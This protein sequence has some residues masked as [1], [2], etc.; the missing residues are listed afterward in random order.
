MGSMDLKTYLDSERGRTSA[1]ARAIDAHA[2]D[3]SAWKTG[4]RPV[5]VH[6]GLP[7][8]KATGGLVTRLDLFSKEVIRQVWPELLAKPRGRKMDRIKAIDDAQNNPGGA[9]DE[10]P[11]KG[12][13]GS[14]HKKKPEQRAV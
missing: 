4:A 8:E 6:F 12:S 13:G 11:K 9:V 2:S 14:S 7:I 5:P 3:V 10:E 1:L